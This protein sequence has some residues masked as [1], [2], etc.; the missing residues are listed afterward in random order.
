MLNNSESRNLNNICPRIFWIQPTIFCVTSTRVTG[1]RD[2]I[3]SSTLILAG[4]PRTHCASLNALRSVQQHRTEDRPITKSNYLALVCV[5]AVCTIYISM[6][7]RRGRHGWC[8]RV[9]ITHTGRHERSD[10]TQPTPPYSTRRLIR[11]WSGSA[12]RPAIFSAWQ[13]PAESA[14]IRNSDGGFYN[15]PCSVPHNDTGEMTSKTLGSKIKWYDGLA[16]VALQHSVVNLLEWKAG[17]SRSV[18]A[19][20]RKC[21]LY[22]AECW[23]QQLAGVNHVLIFCT[24]IKHICSSD[25]FAGN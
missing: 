23:W 24:T 19:D 2:F 13:E 15:S 9:G 10:W 20:P 11:A 5:W 16:L 3:A 22:R 21:S 12:T 14:Y 8:T 4:R 7:M 17:P 1:H 6:D 25:C 18:A